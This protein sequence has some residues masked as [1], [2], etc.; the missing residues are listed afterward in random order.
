MQNC[1]VC[2]ESNRERDLTTF[3]GITRCPDC[4]EE[5]LSR[6]NPDHEM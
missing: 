2:K 3:E 5:M 6:E 4:H 1:D